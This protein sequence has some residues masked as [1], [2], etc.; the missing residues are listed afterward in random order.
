MDEN[1]EALYKECEPVTELNDDIKHII[2]SMVNVMFRRDAEGIAANQLG[3]NKRIIVLN[4]KNVSNK[5]I[6]YICLIN[7]EMEILD[8]ETTYAK[9]GCLSFPG[10]F[11]YLGRPREV[12]VTGLLKDFKTNFTLHAIETLARIVQHEMDH[13][14]GI[15]IEQRGKENDKQESS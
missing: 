7:P 9:E 2:N 10:L 1:N 13:L 11:K 3:F 4:G 8:E 6:D 15:T 12:K 5:D 14:N